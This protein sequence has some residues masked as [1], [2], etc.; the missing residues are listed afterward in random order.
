MTVA[1]LAIGTLAG[2]SERRF[3]GDLPDKERCVPG[4]LETWTLSESTMSIYESFLTTTPEMRAR[5]EINDPKVDVEHFSCVSWL[6][7]FRSWG[8]AL[9]V[10][11]AVLAAVGVARWIISGFKGSRV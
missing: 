4:T 9:G 3:D 11:L 7:L 2:L 1:F 5:G 6:S 8:V 10:A